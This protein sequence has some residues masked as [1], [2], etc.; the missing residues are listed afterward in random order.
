MLI[1]LVETGLA[2][3]K[4]AVTMQ[5]MPDATILNYRLLRSNSPGTLD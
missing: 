3:A 4:E 1:E 2:G 5:N